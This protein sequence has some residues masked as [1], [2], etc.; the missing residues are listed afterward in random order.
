MLFNWNGL[1][2]TSDRYSIRVSLAWHGVERLLPQA[3]T[4]QESFRSPLA[5]KEPKS[6]ARHQPESIPPLSLWGLNHSTT[7]LR[8]H[9]DESRPLSPPLPPPRRRLWDCRGILLG[10]VSFRWLSFVHGHFTV[11]VRDMQYF[12]VNLEEDFYTPASTSVISSRVGLLW[13]VEFVWVCERGGGPRDHPLKG[14]VAW[15]HLPLKYTLKYEGR[16]A[17]GLLPHLLRRHSQ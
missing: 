1:V 13:H 2:K 12:E 17:V 11:L 3:Y 14:V 5:E 4:P 10:L 6:R 7:E 16:L 8:K 9:V 15:A